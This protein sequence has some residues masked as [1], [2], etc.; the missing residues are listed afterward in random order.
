MKKLNLLIA[1]TSF[2]FAGLA[3]AQTFDISFNGSTSTAIGQITVVGGIATSG[4]LDVTA[5]ANLGTYNLVSLTSP[6]I[7]GTPGIGTQTLRIGGAN[8]QIF[9]DVVNTSSNPFLTGNGLE[10]ANSTAVGFNLWGN[11]PGS[12]SL[13]DADNV[14]IIDGG[15]ATL[16][17]A[18]APEP[19]SW[20]IGLVALGGAFYLRRRALRA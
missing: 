3:Q 2:A 19:S 1:V 4:Y 18:A 12:Y 11:G 5:G 13:F 15:A 10:F 7:N 17:P 9:D 16:T 8:D 14:Y 6:L 20:A